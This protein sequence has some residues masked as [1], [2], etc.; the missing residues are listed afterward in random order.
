VPP[1]P[2]FRGALLLVELRS[3]TQVA[4]RGTRSA[5]LSPIPQV[6]AVYNRICYSSG[7]WHCIH[8]LSQRHGPQDPKAQCYASNI[9]SATGAVRRSQSISVA[10]TF[11]AVDAKDVD[12][13][14]GADMTT[15]QWEFCGAL[16]AMPA[17]RRP[18][19]GA[20]G[21]TWTQKGERD[22]GHCDF[23]RTIKCLGAI[24]LY[25][26]LFRHRRC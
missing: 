21:A 17:T 5:S 19:A 14:A 8:Q 2:K 12:V 23:S 24:F 11:G 15:R 3:C 10:V 25:Q 18:A 1:S 13:A 22:D 6:P 4:G 9:V 7:W 26:L 16:L 20:T